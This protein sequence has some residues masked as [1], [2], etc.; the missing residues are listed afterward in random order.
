MAYFRLTDRKG[1][2]G[3]TRWLAT[4]T[5]RRYLVAIVKE[6]A[7]AR[8]A[9]DRSWSRGRTGVEKSRSMAAVLVELGCLAARERSVAGIVLHSFVAGLAT[10]WIPATPTPSTNRGKGRY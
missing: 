3:A 8:Q 6:P 9:A 7:H 5:I 2:L 1:H 10:G 4:A